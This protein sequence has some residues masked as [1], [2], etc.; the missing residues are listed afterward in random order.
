MSKKS[1]ALLII[2]LLTSAVFLVMKVKYNETAT[3]DLGMQSSPTPTSEDILSLSP[4]PISALSG[5]LSAA[6]IVIEVH[7]NAPTLIQLEIGYDP[8]LLTNVSI[9]PGDFF[10]NP[11][12]LLNTINSHTGRI[13]YAI[14]PS[15]EHSWANRTGTIAT[16]TFTPLSS[17]AKTTTLSFLPK[18]VIYEHGEQN[19][20][21][22]GYG[23]SVIISPG[24]VIPQAS[25]S[26][27]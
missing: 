2:F 11:T 9:E 21:K 19:K 23:A 25:T 15:G 13:S 7:G 1:I 14:K 3:P 17:F 4:N 5:K 22:V 8:T 24:V 12:V 18:T 27:Y 26:A 20:L 16:I 6:D 10:A